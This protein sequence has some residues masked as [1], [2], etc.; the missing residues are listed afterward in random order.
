M[1]KFIV[2]NGQFWLDDHPQLIQAGEFHYFRTPR[3]EWRH[4]LGLLK[5]AGFNAVASYI[6]WLWHQLDEDVSDFDGSSHPMRNLAG[7]L[8]LAAEMGLL[9]IARPGPYIN[10]ETINE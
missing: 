4:R 8:D 7:F 6:P 5:A 10:A 9:I 2:K 3:E 1:S